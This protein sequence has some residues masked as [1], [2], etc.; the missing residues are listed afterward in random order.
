MKQKITDTLLV[1]F[2]VNEKNR[3]NETNIQCIHRCKYVKGI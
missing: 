1:I 3:M 2:A